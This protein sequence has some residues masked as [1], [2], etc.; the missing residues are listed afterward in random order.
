MLAALTC[1]LA[2]VAQPAPP[3]QQPDLTKLKAQLDAVCT[4]FGGRMGYSLKVLKT[5]QSIHHRGDERFPT[6]STIKT[7]L[8]LEAIRQVEE[9]TLKWNDKRPVPPDGRREASMWS[10]F[11]K[12]GT[13]LDVDGW[14][15][16]MVGVSDNTA[17]IVMREWL[18]M[19]KTNARMQSLGLPNTK[20]LG[21]FPPEQVENVRLRRMFGLGVTTP[22]EMARLLE[23]VYRNQ[24]ASK[25]GCEKLVRILGRQYWDDAI[26]ATVPVDV[27]VASKSGAI[28]RSRSDTAIVY[29]DQPYVLT[30]YTDNQRDQRWVDDNEGDV[31]LRTLAGLVWNG[32][33]PR[34]PYKLPEGYDK[35]FPTGGGG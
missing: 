31:A 16:L 5:G 9:G 2:L 28:N 17:T 32:L 29:S 18:T 30:I 34:R 4:R 15:N 22:N 24:A 14:V 10:Y 7:A 33:H 12:E 23:L 11:F 1:A 6:A 35:F 26:G 21:T 19:D 13:T 20:V 27:K 3:T 25:A 8:A